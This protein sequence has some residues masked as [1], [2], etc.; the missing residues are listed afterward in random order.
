MN[1]RLCISSTRRYIESRITPINTYCRF[2]TN[3][4]FTWD[5]KSNNIPK[6]FFD[7]IVISHCFFNDTVKHQEA[8]NI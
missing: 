2:V 1:I 6:K 5:E 3:D 7:F 8:T 4:I